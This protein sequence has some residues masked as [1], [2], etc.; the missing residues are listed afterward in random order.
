M[1][2]LTKNPITIVNETF[3]KGKKLPEKDKKP[4]AKS[5]KPDLPKEVDKRTKLPPLVNGR[6][7]Q[8]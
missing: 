3:S 5:E 2:L 1:S 6:P 8:S 7:A 4:D